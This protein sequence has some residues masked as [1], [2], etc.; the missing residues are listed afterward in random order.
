MVSQD[1]SSSIQLGAMQ[2][3]VFEV[4]FVDDVA[5][6]VFAPARE[7]I[8]KTTRVVQCAFEVFRVYGMSLN[9]RTNKSEGIVAFHGRDS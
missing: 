1:I 5:V 8:P 3:D 2:H 9:F 6:P 7:I 4:S